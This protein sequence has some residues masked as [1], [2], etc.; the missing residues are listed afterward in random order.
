MWIL[1]ST[2]FFI[3]IFV[4]F[5]LFLTSNSITNSLKLGWMDYSTLNEN[6]KKKEFF[7]SERIQYFNPEIY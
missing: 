1:I 6:N 4:N 7:S 3:L 5:L 2:T